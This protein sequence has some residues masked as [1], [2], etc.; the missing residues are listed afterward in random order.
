MPIEPDL[1]AVTD[2]LNEYTIP[3]KIMYI[4]QKIIEANPGTEAKGNTILSNGAHYVN[5][6]GNIAL[7][8]GTLMGELGPELV[9]SGG[10]YFVAG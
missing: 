10:R 8:A 5:A 3:E 7:A 6:K 2:A 9:V 1:S 4:R